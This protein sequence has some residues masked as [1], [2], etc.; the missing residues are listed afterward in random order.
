MNKID[1]RGE[2]P[3][4]TVIYNKGTSALASRLRTVGKGLVWMMPDESEFLPPL[5]RLARKR[6]RIFQFWTFKKRYRTPFK[7]TRKYSRNRIINRIK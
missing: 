3:G 6:K 5:P 4:G 1:L 2:I 7:I